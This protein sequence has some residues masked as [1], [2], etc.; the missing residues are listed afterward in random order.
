M[1]NQI[2][3]TARKLSKAMNQRMQSERDSL[4]KFNL[5]QYM[6]TVEYAKFLDEEDVLYG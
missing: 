5:K 4:Y 2:S 6:K 1:E 3:D